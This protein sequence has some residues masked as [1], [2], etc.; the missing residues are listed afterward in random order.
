MGKRKVSILKPAATSVA[1]I[2]FLLKVEGC[3]KRQESL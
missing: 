3:R 2:A 1:E